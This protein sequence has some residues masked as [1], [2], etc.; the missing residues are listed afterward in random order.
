LAPFRV[1]EHFTANPRG[2]IYQQSHTL[3]TLFISILS[4]LGNSLL[5]KNNATCRN[6]SEEMMKLGIHQ[7]WGNRNCN[8]L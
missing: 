4:V 3:A 5:H 8:W 6:D 1:N 7:G 2:E